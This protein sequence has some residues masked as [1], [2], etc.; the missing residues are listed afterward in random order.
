MVARPASPPR[1]LLPRE[2]Y[3]E[4]VDPKLGAIETDMELVCT[5]A[6][7]A[8]RARPTSGA[9][10]KRITSKPMRRRWPST[11]STKLRQKYERETLP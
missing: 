2:L 3:R 5:A 6:S 10:T 9:S 7:A 11:S 8:A 1:P 4:R